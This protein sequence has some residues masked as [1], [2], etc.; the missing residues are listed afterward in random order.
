MSIKAGMI[1]HDIDGYTIDRIQSA[2]V[3]S[4]NISEEK[5]NELGNY[6]AV[7]TVRDIPDLSFDLESTDVS[8]EIEA[9]VVGIDPGTLSGGE[10]IDFNLSL[11]I[12]VISPFKEEKGLFN[13][14]NGVAVP[15]LT[16]ESVTYRFGLRA[17]ATQAWTFKGDSMYYTPG[18]PYYEELGTPNT[19]P[20]TLAE[21]AIVYDE[22]G[23]SIYALSVCAKN[24][25][26]G[27]YKRLLHGTD[28]TDT[29][30]TVTLT[31][32]LS[33]TYDSLHVVYATAATVEYTQAG[34][35]PNG[36]T[37]HEGT[38][39]K[40]AGIRGKDIEVIIGDGAATPTDVSWTGVQSIEATRRVTLE[41]DEEFNN[42]HYVTS[43]Y[44][45]PDVTGN[46]VIKPADTDDLMEKIAQIANVPANE[47]ISTFTTL[48]M[49]VEIRIKNPDDSGN[50]IKTIYIPDARFKVPAVQGRVQQKLSVTFEFT[51]D[52]GTMLVYNGDMP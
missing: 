3:S 1:L 15:Y 17:N 7:A 31:A 40:P 44:D 26:T 21:T 24:S 35:N 49:T 29:S 8:A 16:L 47:V 20:K 41:N 37:V 19:T 14:I 39:V 12:D 5:I 22:S 13:T 46:I 52:S 4:L 38:G 36:N 27:R 50:V 28:Y 48:P 25:T 23:T 43:D 51:S 10:E 30:T 33:A 42:Y 32:D 18:T 11:P 45:T 6:Q 2:G 9:L 34:V